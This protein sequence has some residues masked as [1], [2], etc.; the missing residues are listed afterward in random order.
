M[1]FDEQININNT[2]EFAAEVRKKVI[3]L[4]HKA[5][6]SHLGSALSCV[7]L[8]A[9]LYNNILRID[10]QN[11]NQTG[12]DKFILSK[13]HAA[14]A[15][16]TTLAYK[17]FFP[18]ERLD[19]YGKDGGHLCEHPAPFCVPGIE[20]ATGSLGH[21]LPIGS[22]MALASKIKKKTNRIYVLMSD[23]ECNEGSV[24]EAALFAASKKLGN[25]TAIIDYNKWQATGR[26]DEVLGLPSLKKKWKAFGWETKE[27]DGHNLKKIF[28]ALKKGPNKTGKP[29]M[30]IANTIKGKGVSF[31]E[32]D[33]NWHYRI[34]TEEE[35]KKAHREIDS[36]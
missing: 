12:L 27:I 1:T 35:V 9:V 13:G 32:D 30:I 5:K 34:P 14:A 19:E 15:I 23:G 26:S 28:N 22:G 2:K 20:V 3:E 18:L 24:W 36:K 6:A 21:G 29:R 17:K 11:P 4:S 25:L 7:D 16:Y 8:L 31:M 10:P 33:N